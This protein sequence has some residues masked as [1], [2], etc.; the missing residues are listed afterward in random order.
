MLY[1]IEPLQSTPLVVFKSHITCFFINIFTD[2]CLKQI[3]LLWQCFDLT[4]L[5]TYKSDI[6]KL[7]RLMPVKLDTFSKRKFCCNSVGKN[8]GHG[9]KICYTAVL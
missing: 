8:C 7:D 1:N 9:R 4:K 2:L 6:S 5:I 3:V